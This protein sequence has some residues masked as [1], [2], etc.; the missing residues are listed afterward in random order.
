MPK[1]MR[2]LRAVFSLDDSTLTLENA[3]EF[4]NLEPGVRVHI[5]EPIFPRLKPSEDEKSVAVE[6][7]KPTDDNLLDISEFGKAEMRVAKVLEAEPVEGADKLLKLQVD[8]GDHKR[9]I[10]AG[11]AK[12]YSPEKI[13][14]MNIIVVTNLK[15][16]IIRGVESNGMLLAAS[17]GKKLTLVIPDGDSPLG[18]RVG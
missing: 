12:H 14:G 11:V 9:Q 5:D 3:R 15:P 13:I 6:K 16:A 7:T 1:K 18:A 4:F 8:L 17:K 2:E 10:V